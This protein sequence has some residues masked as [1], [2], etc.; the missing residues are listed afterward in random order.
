MCVVCLPVCF[1]VKNMSVVI[2]PRVRL[3]SFSEFSIENKQL[4]RTL[5]EKRDASK[6]NINKKKIAFNSNRAWAGW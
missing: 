4:V 3:T 2:Q 1:Y 5:Y 6:N